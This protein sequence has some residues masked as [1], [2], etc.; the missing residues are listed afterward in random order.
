MR[1]RS[2]KRVKTNIDTILDRMVLFVLQMICMSEDRSAG[3]APTKSAAYS[4]R[5]S[6]AIVCGVVLLGLTLFVY[7]PWHKDDPVSGTPCPFCHFQHLSASAEPVAASV[8]TAVL[9]LLVWFVAVKSPAVHSCLRPQRV[10]LGRAP[11]SGLFT[12]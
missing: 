10:C 3:G 4:W 7:S 2:G 1:S 5:V 12:I 11:P 8:Q 6:T 9:V